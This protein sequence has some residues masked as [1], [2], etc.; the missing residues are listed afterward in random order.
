MNE[1]QQK[2]L[3]MSKIFIDICK[4]EKLTFFAIAGTALGAVR[5]NGFIPWDDD[6]DFGMP[7]PDFELFLKCA[8][9]Y[10]N[11]PF[12]LQTN[13]TDKNYYLPFAKIRNS[14]TTGIEETTKN[15]KI[16]HGIWI[17]IFPFDGLP[18]S[19]RKRKRLD[20]LQN[21]LFER[22]YFEARFHYRTPKAKIW[23]ILVKI[24]LPSK[25]LAFKWQQKINKRIPWRSC[26]Y[27]WW[28][29]G[30]RAK[31]LFKKEW[32]DDFVLFNFEDIKIPVPK[33]YE[34]YLSFHYGDWKSLP[35]VEKRNSYH[36]FYIVDTK[37][38]Y[39]EYVDNSKK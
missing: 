15:L 11:D 4:K 22:R 25:K 28:N 16:N 8:S 10:L 26:K 5:H 29:W 13:V 24:L 21:Y 3:E 30:T 23:N 32:F 31:R 27:F 20:A 1:I 7:R 6:M 9:K 35:P 34:Q 12:F 33:L 39:L 18:E 36:L 38:S 17:D 37:K 2:L 19:L 14:S